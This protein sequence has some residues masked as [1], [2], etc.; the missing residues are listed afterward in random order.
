MVVP[1]YKSV[2]EHQVNL[3]MVLQV[4]YIPARES[5]DVHEVLEVADL[6]T[7]PALCNVRLPERA[8]GRSG[9]YG[10]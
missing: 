8:E 2:S 1:A 7:F 4:Q 6:S 10:N 9:Y 3:T 5:V